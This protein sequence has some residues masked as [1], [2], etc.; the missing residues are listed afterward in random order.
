MLNFENN[1]LFVCQYFLNTTIYQILNIHTIGEAYVKFTLLRPRAIFTFY[2][3]QNIYIL[4]IIPM[5]NKFKFYKM[6][7]TEQDILL[8]LKIDK[9]PF[10]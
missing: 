6:I 7:L 10:N 8:L 5:A 2:E 4:S 1:D 9:I 3:K